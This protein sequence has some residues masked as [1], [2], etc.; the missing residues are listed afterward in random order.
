MKQHYLALM[1]EEAD[2]MLRNN[3]LKDDPAVVVFMRIS[4][5]AL[6]DLLISKGIPSTTRENI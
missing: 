4:K 1:V 3:L 6:S 5:R 2:H